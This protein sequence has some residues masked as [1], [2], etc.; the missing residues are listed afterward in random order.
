MFALFNPQ[1][2]ISAQEINLI[3]TSVLIM[4]IVAVPML[5]TFF[6]FAWKYR[7]TNPDAKRDTDEHNAKQEGNGWKQS[8]LWAIPT[9]IIIPLAILAW[10]TV[11]AI[12]PSQPITSPNPPLTIQVVALQWKWLF[13]YPAQHVATVNFIQFP[14]NTPVHF[15]L[16]ADAPMS[17]FWIPQLGSQIYAM[18]AMQTQINLMASTTGEFL[19]K[20]TEI[21]GAGY[22]GMTFKAKSS[23]QSD[24]DA[25]VQS[26]KQSSSALD[27][28]A[29]NELAKPSSYNLRQYFSSVDPTLFNNIMIKFIMPPTNANNGSGSG[30]SM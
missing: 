17:S 5:F 28:N 23:S 26:V 10:G 16:T 18:D 21:N 11:H 15:E 19:G 4:L 29:Y 24:F 6:Y 25:W 2:A 8:I 7:A 20:D 13:I 22:A 14:V 3:K 9:A 27:Q 30:M 1:G 12:D